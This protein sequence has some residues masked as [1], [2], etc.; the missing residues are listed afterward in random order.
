[1]SVGVM[2]ALHLVCISNMFEG[3][4][5]HHSTRLKD[6]YAIRLKRARVPPS[7]SRDTAK[8]QYACQYS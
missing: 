2:K 4:Q 6:L 5:P 8:V 3:I 7:D 1:M